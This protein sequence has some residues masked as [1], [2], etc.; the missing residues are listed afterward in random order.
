MV[1]IKER[2]KKFYTEKGLDA[3]KHRLASLIG[4]FNKGSFPVEE[5]ILGFG[6]IYIPDKSYCL[7]RIKE[8]GCLIGEDIKM[9]KTME[10]MNNGETIKVEKINFEK[11]TK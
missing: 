9:E 8:I 4:F 2:N 10:K 1:S 7:E 6:K 11:D 5:Y 3:L